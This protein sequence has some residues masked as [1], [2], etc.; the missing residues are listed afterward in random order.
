MSA[1]RSIIV[2]DEPLARKLLR[3]MLTE[4]EDIEIIAEFGDGEEAVE[5]IRR[6][7]PDLVFLD[8]QMPRKTGIDVLRDLGRER[9]TE[10]VF[11]T[12]YDQYALHAFEAN[13]VDYLLKPFDDERLAETLD[14]V[15]ARVRAS[16]HG[17]AGAADRDP[18]ADR[19]AA[20][21]RDLGDRRDYLERIAVKRGEKIFLQPVD[22]IERFESEGKYVRIFAGDQKFMI[23]ETM[24]QL[25]EL[26]DP[27]KFIRVSRAD[28][29]NIAFIREIEPW[30]R[31]DYVITLKSGH[32][33]NTT[34]AYRDALKKLIDR[35]G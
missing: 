9:D 23:R 29:I 16:R 2:D 25:D 27:R 13:A 5:G 26:L 11:V 10:V 24:I 35:V 34:R 1:L 8:V 3:S 30:F 7:G 28:I 22:D 20:L 17:G 18:Y 32:T 33:V 12:A 15:R 19:I 21:I 4:H 6:E 31:G 14:R